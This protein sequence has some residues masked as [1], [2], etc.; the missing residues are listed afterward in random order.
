VGTLTEKKD[1][2]RAKCAL[3]IQKSREARKIL[4]RSAKKTT[5]SVAARLAPREAR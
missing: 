4:A 3:R 2:F 5:R 1:A